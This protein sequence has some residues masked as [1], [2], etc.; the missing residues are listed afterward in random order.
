MTGL[1]GQGISYTV[2]GEIYDRFLPT[3]A[4]NLK[5]NHA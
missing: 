3:G 5:A 1:L 4:I 2:V